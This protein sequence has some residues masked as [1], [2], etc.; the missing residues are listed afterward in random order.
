LWTVWL[1]KYKQ[2]ITTDMSKS[3]LSTEEYS[4]D[5]IKLM[6]SNNPKYVLRNYIAQ[7]AIQKAEEGDYSE[8]E[9]L[10]EILKHPYDEQ[11][12]N[13]KYSRLPPEW[14]YEICVTCSS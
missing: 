13:E 9:K 12:E 1:N 10:L 7:Q 5:R 2:R 3:P 4:K 8:V 6:N 11:Q 14:S